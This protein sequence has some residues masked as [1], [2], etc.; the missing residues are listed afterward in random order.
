M[1]KTALVKRSADEASD[2]VFLLGFCDWPLIYYCS[3]SMSAVQILIALMC[4]VAATVAFKAALVNE[5]ISLF[6][7]RGGMSNAVIS[8]I[9]VFI[10]ADVSCP[11]RVAFIVLMMYT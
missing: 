8:R 1:G 5:V 7:H 2:E 11:L 3:E 10:T 4:A 9:I 6:S